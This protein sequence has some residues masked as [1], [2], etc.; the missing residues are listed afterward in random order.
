MNNRC[1]A[2]QTAPKIVVSVSGRCVGH[3]AEN[4]RS[5]D[6]MRWKTLKSNL[7]SA[8]VRTCAHR[9]RR[10]KQIRKRWNELRLHPYS[11]D[12][13]TGGIANRACSYFTQSSNVG[14][15]ILGSRILVRPYGRG[16]L[17]TAKID[18]T[19]FREAIF[20]SRMDRPEWS[21]ELSHEFSHELSHELS[22]EFSHELSHE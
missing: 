3:D 21:H 19:H 2:T 11:T 12:I 14:R 15:L 16:I 8:P 9:E 10:N 6:W 17:W 4:T 7:N 1:F 22:H 18:K 13:S 5:K 20:A